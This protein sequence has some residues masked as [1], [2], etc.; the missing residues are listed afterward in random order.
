MYLILA[1]HATF[2][3]SRV[4][5]AELLLLHWAIWKWLIFTF[6]IFLTRFALNTYFL[7]LTSSL[8]HFFFF[9]SCLHLLAVVIKNTDLEVV[10]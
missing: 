2:L 9:F 7:S 8:F 5:D 6:R 4:S 10:S 3:C 1:L